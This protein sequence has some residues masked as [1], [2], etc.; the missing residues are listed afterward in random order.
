MQARTA[1]REDFDGI[2][3]LLKRAHAASEFYGAVPYSEPRGR[4]MLR[5]A[6]ANPMCHMAV[7]GVDRIDG[8]VLGE[9]A[10]AWQF[11]GLLATTR[12]LYSEANGLPLLKSFVSWANAWAGVRKIIV[13]ESFGGDRDNSRVYGLFGLERAGSIFIDVRAQI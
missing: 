11:D 6:W 7:T 12:I 4:R 3:E 5:E 8:V 2:A 1:R 13:A 10:P 9:V